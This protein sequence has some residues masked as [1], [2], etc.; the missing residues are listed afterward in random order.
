MATD[1][2][3]PITTLFLIQSVDG[4]ITTGDVDELDTDLDF[5]RLHGVKEGLHRYYE[6]EQQIARISFNSGRVLAKV[7]ANERR[8]ESAEPDVVTFIIVD[9]RPHLTLAGCEYFARRSPELYLITS[10]R[11]HPALGL[12]GRYP[13]VH[14]LL[15]PDGIDFADAMARLRGEFGIE[16]LT[17]QTGGELNAHLLRLGLIDRLLLVVA[18][19]LVGGRD[20]Q[21][22]IGGESLHDEADLL[23]LRALRLVGCEPLGDSY[24]QLSYEVVNDTMVDPP[25]VHRFG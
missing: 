12:A 8:W 3:R 18:P 11:E 19:C 16:R 14:V 5:R 10:N 15:Y 13:N 24:L 20:T 21:S 7:G 17:I 2:P 25:A 4:K 23:G 1:A 9:S 22:L 6:I